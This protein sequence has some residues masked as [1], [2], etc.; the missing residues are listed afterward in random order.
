MS[1][2]TTIEVDYYNGSPASF[3]S[4]DVWEVRGFLWWTN[5]IWVGSRT[6]GFDGKTTITLVKDKTYHVRARAGGKQRDVY[7]RTYYCPYHLG[8][9]L[10]P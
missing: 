6:A 8:L 7:R 10:P 9:Y 5:E 4:I 1:C 2:A 3:A